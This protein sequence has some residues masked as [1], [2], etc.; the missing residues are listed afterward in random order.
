MSNFAESRY[1]LLQLCDL[2]KLLVKKDASWNMSVTSQAMSPCESKKEPKME[3]CSYELSQEKEGCNSQESSTTKDKKSNESPLFLAT[4]SDIKEIVEAVLKCKPEALKQ[5][6]KEGMNILHVA[7]LYRHI[8]IF[9]MVVKHEV[10]ARRLLSATDNEK[11]SVLHMV[12]QKQ[13]SQASEKMQS[14]A[15]QLRNELLLFEV[16]LLTY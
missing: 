14:P 13:K 2:V 1:K 12:S 5:T 11:N 16:F 7:I 9:D 6:N 3:K 10:L 8:D 4:M 15:L